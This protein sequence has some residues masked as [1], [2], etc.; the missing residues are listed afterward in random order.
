MTYTIILIISSLLLIPGIIMAFIP[1]IPN[2]VYMFAIAIFFGLYDNFFNITPMNILTLA[3]I[4]MIAMLIDFISGIIGAKWGGAHW[5]SIAS[6]IIGL[7]I[8]SVFIPV[9]ILGSLVGMFLGVFSSEY[10]R[11][12]NLKKAEKAALGSFLGFIAGTGVRIIASIVFFV[13][14]I[15]FAWN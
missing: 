5:S 12:H 7:I 9:P 13:L 10:Y 1:G 4:S 14:F 3:I 6:G 15:V 11:T 2:L 8:G